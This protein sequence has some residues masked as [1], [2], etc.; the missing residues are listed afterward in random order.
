M[1]RKE[2]NLY[3]RNSDNNKWAEVIQKSLVIDI[4]ERKREENE[5]NWNEG[6]E[7]MNRDG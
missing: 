6:Q 2:M 5:W 3:E 1:R 4:K 7:R